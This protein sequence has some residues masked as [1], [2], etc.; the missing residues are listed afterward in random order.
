MGQ[1]KVQDGK[2]HVL[3]YWS[4]PLSPAQSQW[5]PSEQEFW[6]LL[7]MRREVVKHFGRIPA[8]IHTDH[9]TLVRLEHLPVERID[10]KHYRWHAELTQGGTLLLYRPGSGALHKLPDVL[11]RNPHLRDQL[12]L[13]RIG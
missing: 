3:L 1:C 11:S 2:L 8:I 5:H 6:G 13:A 10:A 4:A 7:N 12:N 9:G